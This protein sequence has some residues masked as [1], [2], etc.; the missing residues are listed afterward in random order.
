[1]SAAGTVTV[2]AAQSSHQF[3]ATGWN[4]DISGRLDITRDGDA[5]PVASFAPG[6]WGAVYQDSAVRT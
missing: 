4:T 2:L 1:M 6:A 3:T 5:L